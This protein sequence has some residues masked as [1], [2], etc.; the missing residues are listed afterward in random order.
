[1]SNKDIRRY[2]SAELEALRAERGPTDMSRAKAKTK[3]DLERDIASDPDWRDI[4]LTWYE[5]AEAVIPVPIKL[6][7]LVLETE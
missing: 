4:S 6:L 3:A 1:M 2:T 5:A 7:P